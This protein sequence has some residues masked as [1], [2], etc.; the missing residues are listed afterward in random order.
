MFWTREDF[1]LKRFAIATACALVTFGIIWCVKDVYYGEWRE[2]PAHLTGRQFI[3]DQSHS[4]VYSYSCGD[5]KAPRTCVGTRWVSI[6]AQH[7][8]FTVEPS[9]A[10]EAFNDSGAFALPDGARVQ[11]VARCGRSGIRWFLHIKG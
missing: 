1:T 9:G 2:Y 7:L 8:V 4:E 10:S 5:S 6:P 3:P 11:L